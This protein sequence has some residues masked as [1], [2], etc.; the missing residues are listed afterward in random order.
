MWPVLPAWK[1]FLVRE[2][3]GSTRPGSVALRRSSEIRRLLRG[4]LVIPRWHGSP[5]QKAVARLRATLAFLVN[6]FAATVYNT[7]TIC[8]SPQ[9]A[10][11][12]L[13]TRGRIGDVCESLLCPLRASSPLAT[14]VCSHPYT[15]EFS[16]DHLF[17]AP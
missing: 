14:S 4:G 7:P 5:R 9:V 11:T 2:R 8:M 15:C 3:D 13:E 6:A 17:M 10:N 1:Q 12:S 16:D